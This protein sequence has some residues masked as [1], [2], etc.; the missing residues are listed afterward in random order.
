MT[1]SKSDF[2]Q[3]KPMKRRF[4]KKPHRHGS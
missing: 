4:K 2:G 1:V 3:E